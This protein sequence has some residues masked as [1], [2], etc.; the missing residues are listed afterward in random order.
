MQGGM[1]RYGVDDHLDCP[2][3]GKPFHL[4]RRTAH[5]F[6]GEDYELQS[7]SCIACGYRMNR[8]VDDAGRSV[9]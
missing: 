7:F 5:P 9:K 2:M 3:C 8:S 6:H 1:S 4:T